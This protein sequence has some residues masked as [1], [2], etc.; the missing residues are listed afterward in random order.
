[1]LHIYRIHTFIYII[2]TFIHAYHY[3]VIHTGLLT[4]RSRWTP[5]G[6]FPPPVISPGSCY[7]SWGYCMVSIKVSVVIRPLESTDGSLAWRNLISSCVLGGIEGQREIAGGK[8]PGGNHP[9]GNH[10]G[11]HLDPLQTIRPPYG[12]HACDMCSSW[13]WP[14]SLV[15]WLFRRT[16]HSLFVVVGLSGWEERLPDVRGSIPTVAWRPLLADRP[17]RNDGQRRTSPGRILDPGHGRS[18]H[19]SV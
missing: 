3:V 12:Y 10:R 2:Y 17:Q 14:L 8:L 7:V 18:A 4:D 15:L 9:G 16:S 19:S 11:V 6:D 5:P 1:M 13:P